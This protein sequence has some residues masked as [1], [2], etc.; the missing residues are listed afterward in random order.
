MARRRLRSALIDIL[1]LAII[2]V[3][4]YGLYN[5]MFASIP[6]IG[7]S[8][9]HTLHDA[10]KVLVYKTG[11]YGFGDIVVFNTHLM[12][13]EGER[14]FVKRIIGLPGDEVSINYDRDSKRFYVWRNGVR[15]DEEYINEDS[16]MNAEM[17]SI[18]VPEG[19][20][21]FL[22]DNRGDSSDSRTGLLGR[23]DSIVGRVVARYRIDS[24]TFDINLIKRTQ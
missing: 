13:D 24:D 8:M 6:V 14:H 19:E 10:D 4:V 21:F 3:L 15:L 17:P 9:E 2:A 1:F 12:G 7:K 22:G 5:Y 16:P 20:F 18:T 23:L 11:K